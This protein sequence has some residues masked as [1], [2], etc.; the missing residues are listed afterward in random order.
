MYEKIN[1]KQ[2]LAGKAILILTTECGKI[3]LCFS[4]SP[5]EKTCM[6]GQKILSWLRYGGL[7]DCYDQALKMDG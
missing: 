3:L 6:A 1:V 4:F 2:S 5:A 7:A